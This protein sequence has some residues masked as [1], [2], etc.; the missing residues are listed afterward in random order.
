M[1]STNAAPQQNEAMLQAMMAKTVNE[2]SS[3]ELISQV[4]LDHAPSGCNQYTTHERD[5]QPSH[6][7]KHPSGVCHTEKEAQAPDGQAKYYKSRG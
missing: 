3:I 2:L 1:I 7:I 4:S 5:C 6:V